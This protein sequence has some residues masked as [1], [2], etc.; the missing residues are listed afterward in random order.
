VGETVTSGIFAASDGGSSGT[1]ATYVIGGAAIIMFALFLR[2]YVFADR[3]TRSERKDLIQRIADLQA[4]RTR[5]ENEITATR[6][7]K[8]TADT[9]AATAEASVA[10][11][12]TALQ[13]SHETVERLKKE[14][15]QLEDEVKRLQAQLR[16]EGSGGQSH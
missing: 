5:L 13:Y 2:S 3:T 11:L 8:F 9:R 7:A 16:K 4:E 6:T 15:E 10:G 1:I 12:T 14:I